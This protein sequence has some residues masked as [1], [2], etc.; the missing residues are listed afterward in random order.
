M[1]IGCIWVGAWTLPPM[2][3]PDMTPAI[4]EGRACAPKAEY[5]CAA[6]VGGSAAVYDPTGFH[7]VVSIFSPCPAGDPERG[8]DRLPQADAAGGDDPAVER[9]HLLLAAARFSR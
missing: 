4:C 7:A 6:K 5:R 3:E 2:H 1:A 9:R 8:G